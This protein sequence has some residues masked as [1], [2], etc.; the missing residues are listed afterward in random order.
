MV[1]NLGILYLLCWATFI[2]AIIEAPEYE[3]AW[4]WGND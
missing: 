4:E 2:E 1:I 3:E